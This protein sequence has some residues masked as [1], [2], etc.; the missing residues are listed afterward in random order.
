MS[1]A[2]YFRIS[3]ARKFRK[4]KTHFTG[5]IGFRSGPFADSSNGS[6]PLKSV[7]GGSEMIGYIA[8]VKKELVEMWIYFPVK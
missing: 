2:L 5:A 8:F 6:R 3:W 7:F 1:K 4:G